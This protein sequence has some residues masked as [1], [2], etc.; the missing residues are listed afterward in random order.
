[1]REF[2]P[3]VSEAIRLKQD[4]FKV[5]LVKVR[6]GFSHRPAPIEM[7]DEGKKL[8]FKLLERGKLRCPD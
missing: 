7:Q 8:K 1:M 3:I 6:S 4:K 5:K 2:A